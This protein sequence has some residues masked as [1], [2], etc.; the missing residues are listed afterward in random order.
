MCRDGSNLPTRRCHNLPGKWLDN[1]TRHC[2]SRLFQIND[3]RFYWPFQD[4]SI[5]SQ[6]LRL[7]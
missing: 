6:P 5:G 7:L 4:L 3:P 2:L 1:A